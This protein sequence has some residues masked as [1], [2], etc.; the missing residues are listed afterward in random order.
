MAQ[1]YRVYVVKSTISMPDPDMPPPRYHTAIFVESESNGGGYLH[2]V[3][4]DL[5]SIGGMRYEKTLSGRPEHADAFYAKD[6]LGV[7]DASTYPSS[8]DTMLRQ[9]PPP[10]Q[11]KAFNPKTMR[12]EPFKN[13]EPLTFYKSDEPRQPLVKCTEWTL[14]QAIPALRLAGLI[15]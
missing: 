10:R 12:T 6:L 3:T 4:G 11:Q 15:H 1:Q 7:T 9:V 13:V 14:D 5:T 2:H 8:W